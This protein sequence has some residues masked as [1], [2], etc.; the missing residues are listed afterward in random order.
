MP[1]IA[2]KFGEVISVLL[3]LGK[4][5]RETRHTGIARIA[6]RVNDGCVGQRQMD[7][8]GKKEITVILS[9]TRMAPGAWRAISS[10]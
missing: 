4:M 7:Q 9:V 3:L 1:V 6:D 10:T 2:A 5:H 8:A